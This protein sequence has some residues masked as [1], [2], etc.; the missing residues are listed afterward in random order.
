MSL[1][2]I[3]LLF[4]A[5]L[6]VLIWM[7]QM[8]VYPSFTFYNQDNLKRWHDKYTRQITF[9]VMPLMFGQLA[10]ISGQLWEEVTWY[11]VLSG[12]FVF[13]LWSSTFLK[14][15]PLHNRITKDNFDNKTLDDLV[16]YNWGRTVLWSALFLISVVAFLS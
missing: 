8:V 9:V 16:R 7:V 14:F 1:A 5:G 15:V 6:L 2:I 3:R 11:T 13:L 10:A 4:D 12:V